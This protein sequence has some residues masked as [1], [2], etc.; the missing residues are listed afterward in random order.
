MSV[1]QGQDSRLPGR[2]AKAARHPFPARA[3]TAKLSCRKQ[4][5]QRE[6]PKSMP[7]QRD[8]NIAVRRIYFYQVDVG[9]NDETGERSPFDESSLEAIPQLDFADGSA[10]LDEEETV[11]CAWLDRPHPHPRLRVADIRRQDLPQL[12]LGGALGPLAID[13]RAGLAEQVHVTFYDNNIAGSDF[14]FYGPRMSRVARYLR[15][16]AGIPEISFDYLVRRD[17]VHQ[18]DQLQ[19]IRLFQLRIAPSHVDEIGRLDDSVADMFRSAVAFGDPGRV[20]VILRPVPYSREPLS[21]RVRE[22]LRALTGRRETLEAADVFKTSGRVADGR[23]RN[24]DLLKDELVAE[25]EIRRL[26]DGSRALDR[27]S[28]YTAIDS[29]YE[30]LRAD[31]E[32]AGGA[33]EE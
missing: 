25:R 30:E 6:D 15:G 14:N 19:D 29:A 16:K 32:N 20:E 3:A 31:L 17:I 28:V 2:S 4:T 26:G 12:E 7:G 8:P 23:I 27:D 11:T 22:A 33:R 18:L 10:Y 5:M 9:R 13:Q 24:L 21:G 1:E